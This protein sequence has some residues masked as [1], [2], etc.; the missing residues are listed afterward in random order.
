M[1]K[2]VGFLKIT[3]TLGDITFYQTD[4]EFYA[5]KKS[6]LDG[7]RVKKDPRFKR[8]MEEAGEF[9][10]AAKAAREIYCELPAKQRGHGVFGKLTGRIRKLI[11]EGKGAE[12]AKREL[13]KEFGSALGE[14]MQ[15]TA[16]KDLEKIDPTEQLLQEVFTGDGTGNR[17]I[18][19]TVSGACNKKS[20]FS[21]K[22]F[23]QQNKVL[24]DASPNPVRTIS[25]GI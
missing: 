16:Q 10:K 9:G 20:L 12:Q 18:S 2:Q 7:K 21:H 13:M 19:V 22:P 24:P 23:F 6:S 5:R 3:G 25:N 1:A 11:R 8:T 17:T 14:N 15:K 4:G